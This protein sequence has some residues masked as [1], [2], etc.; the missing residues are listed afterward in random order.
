MGAENS[1]MRNNIVFNDKPV[2]KMSSSLLLYDAEQNN[3]QIT[4]FEEISKDKISYFQNLSPLER[5]SK[6]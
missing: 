3:I 6:V 4:V 1:N 2:E 5:N